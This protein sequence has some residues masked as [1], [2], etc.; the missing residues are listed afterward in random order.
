MTNLDRFFRVAR[1]LRTRLR[2]LSHNSRSNRRLAPESGQRP[3]SPLKF[4]YCCGSPGAR[5]L[6]PARGKPPLFSLH[7]CVTKRYSALMANSPSVTRADLFAALA[8]LGIA[9]TT[10]EHPAVF[11]VAE[12]DALAR[13]ITG[14]HTKNLFLKDARGELFLIVAEAHTAVDLRGLHKA[15]GCARLSFGNAALLTEVLGVTPGSVTAFAAINDRMA[16][17]TLVVDAAL[18]EHRDINCHPLVNT[19][20]TTISRD[21]L[22]RFLTSTGHPPRILG[23]GTPASGS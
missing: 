14:G 12:S 2:R 1:R 19:A 23:L 15:L 4:Q 6:V 16:R 3:P 21:D 18:M 17:V 7:L 10:V 8:Q 13:D 9:T 11:T 5:P 22:I 20:T